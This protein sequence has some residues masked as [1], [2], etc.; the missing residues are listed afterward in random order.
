MM[1]MLR[2]FEEAQLEGEDVDDLLKDEDDEEDEL[3]KA[4]NGVDLGKLLPTE[5]PSAREEAPS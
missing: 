1:E 3:E 4:L 5:L 2:R